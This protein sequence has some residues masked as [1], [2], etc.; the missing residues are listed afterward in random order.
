MTSHSIA[1]LAQLSETL[2]AAIAAQYD[3]VARWH[4]SG[5]SDPDPEAMLAPAEDGFA[6]L[7]GLILREHAV[8]HLLW[9]VE[10]RARRRDVDDAVI[11][12]CKRDIDGLN[13][14]RNDAMEAV[15]QALLGLVT[16]HLPPLEGDAA[17]RYNTESA[18]GALDRLSILSLKRFHMAE[19]CARTDVDTDHVAQCQGKLAVMEEQHADLARGVLELMDDYVSGAKRPKV[20]YQFKMYNDPRLNPELYAAGNDT[21]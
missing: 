20:Y 16:P 11:A 21:P 14:R 12:Q 3:L 19:Q 9:H 10:D 15:D 5:A 4:E 7:R 13:Q 6:R 1:F 17:P 2:S 18:G 8:N